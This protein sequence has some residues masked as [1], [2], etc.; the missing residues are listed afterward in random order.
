MR[1][2]PLF[3]FALI[4]SALLCLCQERAP[5]QENPKPRLVRAHED[6]ELDVGTVLVADRKLK[7]PNFQQTVILIVKYDDDGTL[8][9]ALN[10]ETDVPVSRVLADW[11]EAR[12]HNEPVFLGGPMEKGSILALA[13]SQEKIEADNVVGD[14]Y[15]ISDKSQ[16]QKTLAGTPGR[17]RLRVYVGY[18]GWAPEQLEQEIDAGAWHTIPGN[19]AL[20]FDAE[21]DSLWLRL[22]QRTESEIAGLM[23]A[24]QVLLDCHLC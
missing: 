1:F 13:R 18:A 6:E 5:A 24:P 16:L 23:Q 11:Q 21:P 19:R 9:L 14:V 12:K 2:S 4:C 10:R 7:D 15:V 20:I 8:G 22:I 3:V 17:S